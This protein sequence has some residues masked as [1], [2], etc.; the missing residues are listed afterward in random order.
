[1]DEKCQ[2]KFRCTSHKAYNES[3]CFFFFDTSLYMFVP[4]S[5]F[6]ID[7]VKTILIGKI[8]NRK[9]KTDSSK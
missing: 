2:N 8:D 9:Y 7:A 1:M 5:E 6:Y 4:C 3:F